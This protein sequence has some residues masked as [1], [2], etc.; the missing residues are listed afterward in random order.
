MG[1][2][3]FLS[4][5][6]VLRPGTD[7]ES[8][9]ELAARLGL[10]RHADIP[11][12]EEEG[13]PRQVIWHAET[14]PA[15]NYRE[16][17]F[18]ALPYVVVTAENSHDLSEFVDIVEAVL[19][20]WRVPE[21]LQTVDANAEPNALPEAILRMGLGAPKEFDQ[22]FFSHV[23]DA[24]GVDREDVREAALL[25]MTYQPWSQYETLIENF[26][27]QEGMSEPLEET[28]RIIL[29]ELEGMNS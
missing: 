14:G 6:M 9:D 19:D 12:N 24:L 10:A 27:E 3:L 18:S 20:T 11:M 23:R 25:A 26:L 21:L 8:V 28:A 5:R 1:S 22:D 2:N 16:D 4:R 15:L 7:E 13:V 17:M 29:D